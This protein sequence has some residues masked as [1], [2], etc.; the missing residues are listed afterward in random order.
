MV[1]GVP[2]LF[3]LAFTLLLAYWQA[4]AGSQGEPL[5]R[6]T[7]EWG[8][9]TGYGRSISLGASKPGIDF[10]TLMPRFGY[11]FTEIQGSP[12]LHGTLA[13]VVEAVPVLL[14]FESET[15]YSGGFNLLLR[16]D[17]ATGTG[18]VP[19]LE[20]GAG[21]LLST[22]QSTEPRSQFRASQ[23]NFTLQVAPGIRYFIGEG[24]AVSIEY[25]LHHISDASTTEHNPGINT[26]F[27]LL[28]F[29]IVR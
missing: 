14:A 3:C 15:I 7:I 2:V 21:I 12:L 11:V 17:F 29:S 23:F 18:V 9:M 10:I 16:Y 27:V 28:G 20:G 4:G 5:K 22:P 19:F 25:R 1:R 6:G 26:N 13:A 24:V 8:V